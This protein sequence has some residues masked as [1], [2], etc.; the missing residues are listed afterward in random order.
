M[1]GMANRPLIIAGVLTIALMFISARV[2]ITPG[3]RLGIEAA[4]SVLES[5]LGKLVTQASVEVQETARSL[6]ILSGILNLEF[7]T[8][9]LGAFLVTLGILHRRKKTKTADF[10][11][12][13]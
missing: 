9:L 7:P 3:A 4:G 6:K 11:S 2:V 5:P 12:Q 13:P 1:I 8:Y 10:T